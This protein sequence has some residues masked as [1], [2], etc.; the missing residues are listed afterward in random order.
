MPTVAELIAEKSRRVISA[1]PDT[2]VLDAVQLM[3]AEHIGSVIVTEGP[4]VVGIFT[5]RDVMNRVVAARRDPAATRLRDVMT[6][7][8][9]CA[10]PE[11]TLAECSSLMTQRNLRHVPIVENGR[12][13]GMVSGGDIIARENHVQQ[14]TILYLHEYLHG[15]V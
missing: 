9:A 11:T 5:E 15:R 1:A 4:K 14:Q 3:S 12:A 13:I 8:V 7:P 6:T 10:T 2:T